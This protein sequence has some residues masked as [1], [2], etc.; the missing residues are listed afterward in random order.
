MELPGQQM[1]E[2]GMDMR[3]GIIVSPGSGFFPRGKIVAFLGMV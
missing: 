1:A 3:A 2:N